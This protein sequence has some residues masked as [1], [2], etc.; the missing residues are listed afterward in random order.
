MAACR[1][2]GSADRVRL[3]AAPAK[4]GVTLTVSDQGT[5]IAAEHLERIFEPDFTTKSD[6]MGLGLAIVENIVLGH[7]GRIG[8]Q[9]EPGRGTTFTIDL[10][11][12]PP[13]NPGQNDQDG[14]S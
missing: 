8:V 10:P 12:T 7:G 11:L 6:G 5:G 4:T 1:Q 9:S 14:E 2:Q 13:V 3:S